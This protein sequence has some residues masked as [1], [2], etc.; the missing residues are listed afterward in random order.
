MP[1]RTTTDVEYR[2]LWH[3]DAE[4]PALDPD[5]R[6]PAEVDV[7]VVGAG[8]CGLAAGRELAGRGRSVAVLEREPLGFGASTRNGGMVIPEL[9]APPRE[10]RRHFGELGARM[11]AAVNDA[12]DRTEALVAEEAIDCD[13]ERTGQLYLAHADRV[14]PGMRELASAL[15]E[16]DEDV[17]LVE[18]AELRGEIGSSAFPAGLVIARTGG[19]HPAKF[20]SALA[21]LALDSGAQ[22]FDRTAVVTVDRRPGGGWRVYTNRSRIDCDQLLLAANATIDGTFGDLRRRVVPVG[23]Y[24]IATEPLPP[25]LLDELSPRR[26]MFV[27]SKNFLFYWRLSPDG[28]MVFGGRKSLSPPS[29]EAACEYLAT[30]LVRIHPQLRDVAV[31]HSWGGYVALTLDRLPHC[32][33]RDDVWYATGCNGSG[34]AL[35]P[36]LGEQLAAAMSGEGP[37]P[38]FAE[39]PHR[40]VPLWSLRRATLP[41]AGVWFA[42]QDRGLIP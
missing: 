10:L 14:V 41:L 6:L 37:L 9:H 28:R 38:P 42:A 8:Y 23:S 15:A 31:T 22:V 27:D 29:P 30:E 25:A 17:H 18:G 39:V 35:M 19:L 16:D 1:T 7:V 21:R 40:P 36:W 12:F 3:D 2:V 11:W 24:V 20:H 13:Y 5:R 32:G 34:V 33:V 26:R 4:P